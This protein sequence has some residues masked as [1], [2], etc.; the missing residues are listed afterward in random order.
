VSRRLAYN[1][2][3]LDD[4]KRELIIDIEVPPRAPGNEPLDTPCAF[5]NMP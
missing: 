3:R 5:D 4:R 2:Y 1:F